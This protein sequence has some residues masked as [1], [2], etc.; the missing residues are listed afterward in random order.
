M[1]EACRI[2]YPQEGED[3]KVGRVWHIIWRVIWHVVWHI[4]LA[5]SLA[6]LFGGYENIGHGNKDL[7]HVIFLMR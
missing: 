6:Y 5:Y 7:Q 1:M 4:V 2:L 3:L